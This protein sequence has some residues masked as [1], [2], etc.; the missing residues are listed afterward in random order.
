MAM[1]ELFIFQMVE[2]QRFEKCEMKCDYLLV[3]V[4]GSNF[5]TEVYPHC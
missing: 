1:N 4:I 5:A 2:F 3:P